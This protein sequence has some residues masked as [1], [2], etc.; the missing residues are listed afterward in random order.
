MQGQDA[1]RPQGDRRLRRE[2]RA[3]AADAA[4]ERDAL[5]GRGDAEE[6]ADADA[7]VG[8]PVALE[9]VP[10]EGRSV[11]RHVGVHGVAA[12]QPLLD[13]KAFG[14]AAFKQLR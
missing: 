10:L 9:G 7:P 4:P 12:E 3:A 1:D 2:R 6:V 11:G 14:V 5:H 13:V 8:I